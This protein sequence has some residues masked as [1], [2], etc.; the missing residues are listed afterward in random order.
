[1]LPSGSTRSNSSSN[2]EAERLFPAS[3]PRSDDAA[4]ARPPPPPHDKPP[5]TSATE[6]LPSAR[7]LKGG[8]AQVEDESSLIH[9]A[10][11]QALL[12]GAINIAERITGYDLDGDGDIGET[13]TFKKQK[14][15]NSLVDVLNAAIKADKPQFFLEE[16]VQT[17][18]DAELSRR[19]WLSN[20]LLLRAV[21]LRSGADSWEA[22]VARFLQSKGVQVLLIALLLMDVLIVFAELFLE[23]EYPGCKVMRKATYSCCPA[24]ASGG[25]AAAAAGAAASAATAADGH[26]ALGSYE[27]DD[28]SPTTVVESIV[29]VLLGAVPHHAPGIHMCHAGEVA[30]ISDEIEAVVASTGGGLSQGNAYRV[31]CTIEPWSHSLHE[32][33]SLCTLL[34]LFFFQVEIMGLMA[35]FRVSSSSRRPFPPTVTLGPVNH[36]PSPFPPTAQHFSPRLP[37]HPLLAPPLPNSS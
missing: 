9:V 24:E 1:M 19:Y 28:G 27:E 17:E 26:R 6:A 13:G 36:P 22:K 29:T 34:I 5:T 23:T 31:G 4:A 30:M 32:L 25:A 11:S 20:S 16:R 10:H 14:R 2:S 3:A 12:E 21:V 18:Q 15:L 37:A 8:R 7:E 33:F 35:S